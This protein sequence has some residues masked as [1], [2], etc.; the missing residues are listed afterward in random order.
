MAKQVYYKQCRLER[1]TD[2]GKL[3]LV[4]YIPEQFAVK[5][6]VLKLRDDEGVWTDGWKV[7][8]ASPNRLETSQL[9]DFHQISKAHLRATGDSLPK[10]KNAS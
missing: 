10:V 5:D 6:K 9:P 4:S 1:K 7:V 2:G 3:N 8:G